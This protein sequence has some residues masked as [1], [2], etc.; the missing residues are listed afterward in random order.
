MVSPL[1][2]EINFEVPG[3]KV[4]AI[5]RPHRNTGRG[6]LH[7]PEEI[8]GVCYSFPLGE[9][10]ECDR[11]EVFPHLPVRNMG[12]KWKTRFWN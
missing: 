8:L 4:G 10:G 5:T 12:Y 7:P 2:E 3:D 6:V 11:C 9:S 1:Q